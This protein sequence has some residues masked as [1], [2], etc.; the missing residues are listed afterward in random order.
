METGSAGRPG[1]P[2]AGGAPP[3]GSGPPVGGGGPPAEGDAGSAVPVVAPTAV[4]ISEI[5]YHPVLEDAADDNHEFVEIH[6]RDGAPVAIAGWRLQGTIRYTFPAGATLAPGQFLVVAR[7]KERLLQVTRYALAPEAVAGNYEG[8][9]DDGGAVVSLARGDGTVVDAVAYDDAFPWPVAAD[10]LGAG[11]KWLPSSLL[12]LESHRFM[13]VSLERIHLGSPGNDVSNW[14]PSPVDG[15]TPGRAN[16]LAQAG[17]PPAMVKALTA[18]PAAGASALIRATDAVQIEVSLSAGP[19]DQ[20][21]V[22]YFVDEL[23]RTDEKPLAVD[24]IRVGEGPARAMLPAQKDSALVRYRIS[25]NRGQGPEVLSPRPSDPYR[26]HGYFVTPDL[27]NQTRT[28]HIV[29]EPADWTRLWRNIEKGRVLRDGGPEG[30]D[31]CRVN[32]DWNQWVPASFVS[33]GKV[34]AAGLRYQGSKWNRVNGRNLRA[35]PYPG[36][37]APSPLKALSLHLSFPRF[38]QFEGRSDLMLK[39]NEVSCPGIDSA[40]GGKLYPRAGIPATP[41]RYARVQINGGYYHYMNEHVRVGEALIRE[42]EAWKGQPIGDLFKANGSSNEGPYA[43]ADLKPIPA[44][45]GKYFDSTPPIVHPVEL[46]YGMTYERKTHKWKGEGQAP[47]IRALAEGLAAAKA[48]GTA[49]VRTFFETNFDLPVLLTYVAIRNW[50]MPMDDM[51]DDYYL[52]RRPES[53][54]WM[55]LPWDLDQEFGGR[56]DPQ[57]SSDFENVSFHIGEQGDRSNYYNYFSF[58]KDAFIKAFRSE[59]NARLKELARDVLEP[60]SVSGLVDE[61]AATF[62]EEEARQAP[63]GLA[64]DFAGRVALYKRFAAARHRG[65]LKLP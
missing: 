60:A 17:P 44:G 22:E 27:K 52:Y 49:E 48:K 29:V 23:G 47:E 45:C 4:V 33:E 40:L 25:G 16:S 41:T 65:V 24:L 13:G 56:D 26:W 8:G 30:T 57:A 59:L 11:D 14:G 61:I 51:S 28:Y 1:A 15:A 37:S 10:A 35:W 32:P 9:L 53:G 7:N 62:Q 21:Q 31:T 34:Y 6:N 55:V 36:P 12:P 5:M 3:V 39:K 43:E 42:F 46:R 50:S 18:A 19:V 64:C 2:P 54:K 20:L 58:W 63:A 38:S